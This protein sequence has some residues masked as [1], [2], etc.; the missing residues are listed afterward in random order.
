MSTRFSFFLSEIPVPVLRVTWPFFK[1]TAGI[2]PEGKTE[3]Q[4]ARMHLPDRNGI[5]CATLPH[6]ARQGGG[7]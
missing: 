7:I 4:I 1:E 6:P 5:V 3:R 2:V